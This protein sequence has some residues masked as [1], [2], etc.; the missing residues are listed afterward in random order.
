MYELT[1]LGYSSIVWPNHFLLA[2]ILTVLCP[3]VQLLVYAV[4]NCTMA[5]ELGIQQSNGQTVLFPT[6]QWSD[7][8]VSHFRKGCVMMC[9]TL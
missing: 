6:V 8:P 1:S 5:C 4:S 7:S 9:Q 2:N 3:T